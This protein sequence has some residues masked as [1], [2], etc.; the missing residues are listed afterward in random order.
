MA[1][2]AKADTVATV[3]A[4]ES[5]G[6]RLCA[7]L[8]ASLVVFMVALPLCIAI[9]R[10]CGLPPESGILSGIVGGVVVGLLA[11]CPLQVSGPAAGLIVLV[12][13]YN[14]D[15]GFVGLM[16]AIF[17]AGLIQVLAALV[18][19][20]RYFRAVA[21]AVIIGMLAGIGVVILAK[22]F[23]VMID[24]PQPVEVSVWRNIVTI[25]QAL[26][27]AIEP[28]H[29][30]AALVG[31]L[32]ILTL[33]LWR[34]LSPKRLRII[35]AALVAVVV[36]V[37][38]NAALG[39]GVRLLVVQPSLWESIHWLDW[40]ALAVGLSDGAVWQ[41]ALVIAFI[42]S[43][44]TLL[45]AS[46]VDQMHTGPRTR[47]N[48]ELFAQGVGNLCCGAIGAM[49][50]TGVIVRSSANVQAGAR[51]R[52]SAVLHGIWL[53]LFVA[54]L[55][56]V[57][58]QIPSACLGA[59]L[60]YTGWRLMNVGEFAA[61]FR[62]SRSEGLIALATCAMVVLTNLLE[63][64]ILGVVLS[65]LKLVITFTHLHIR[66]VDAPERHR[67]DL[68]LE[69]AATFIRL[70]DLAAEL[71]R[72]PSGTTLHVHFD[73]LTYIDHACLDLLMSW[74]QQHALTGGKL[75]IDWSA[76]RARFR[77]P[78]DRVSKHTT[79]AGTPPSGTQ[80]GANETVNADTH[81]LASDASCVTN[82][83][84]AADV[85]HPTTAAPLR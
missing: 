18:G 84:H 43:A 57:L 54:M 61:L 29:R 60:V 44:E 2:R 81:T 3:P 22:Q 77:S 4:N 66:R 37:A 10:A 9:A 47:Y 5:L 35:P 7:D 82:S 41:A 52:L 83:T 13:D 31:V 27:K 59:I 19:F 1:G 64:V 15:L 21:P 74:Q 34:P 30:G 24:D 65:V 68:Y 12:L 85:A 51:T 49:P 46:A 48:R 17:L 67:T 6:S 39:L 14:R 79:Q 55:P 23:H 63:G 25:P 69:G 45:C 56:G 8:L 70:P 28:E 80:A 58:Q 78:H 26:A 76:L 53:L 40:A 16:Q 75:V 38:V 42:A 11:G 62:E 32:T 36:A 50:V 72:V 73:E 71:E 20:G 33:I